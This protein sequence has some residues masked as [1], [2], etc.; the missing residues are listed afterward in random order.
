MILKN[1]KHLVRQYPLS[2][3]LSFVGLTCAFTAFLVIFHQVE[4]EMS[5]DTC[6]PTSERI[7]RADKKE[8]DNMFRSVLPRGFCDDI[9]ASSPHVVAG[10]TFCPFYGETQFSAIGEGTPV[11]VTLQMNIASGGFI[12]VFGIEMLEGDM[13]A[14]E[15]PNCVILP[16]SIA[17]VLFGGK[18]AVGQMLKT[19]AA[20]FLDETDGMVTVTGVYRDFPSNTQLEN[21]VYLSAGH[22]EE[23]S[24]GG[25]NFICYM[26]L[27]DNGNRESVEQQFNGTFDFSKYEGWLTPIE[28]IKY[29]DIYFRNEGNVFKSGSYTQFLLLIAIAVLILLTGMIN[30][31][32]FYI[33][34][35]PMRMKSV[36]TRMVFGVSKWSLQSEVIGE[37]MVWSA[38]AFGLALLLFNPVCQALSEH[39]LTPD[40]FD[41]LSSPMLLVWALAATLVTGAV[42]GILPGVYSTSMEPA[43]ALKGNFG[44]SRSGRMMRNILVYVQ[45]IVS[46][47]LFIYVL[48]IERQGEYIENYPCGFEKENL[49]AVKLGRDMSRRDRVAIK[50]RLCKINGVDNVAFAAALLGG[51]EVYNTNSYDF[52]EGSC[53]MSMIMCSYDFPKVMGMT[54]VDGA[55]FTPTGH[56]DCLITENIKSVGGTLKKMDESRTLIGFVNNVNITSLR[57]AE[58]YVCFVCMGEN[59]E[60]ELPYAY[61]R[62]NSNADKL[63]M[64]DEIR[65]VLRDIDP[66]QSFDLIFYTNIKGLLYSGEERLRKEIWIF[67]MLAILLSLVGIWGQTLMDVKYRGKEI[68]VKRV[69]GASGMQIIG[70]GLRHYGVMVGICFVIACPFAYIASEQYLSQFSR[71]AGMSV[72]PFIVS[73]VAVAALTLSVVAYHYILCLRTNPANV[74]KHE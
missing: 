30:F 54:V 71:H 28:L 67:S 47:V 74:L 16:K 4:Y 2:L 42:A 72:M 18:S 68:S 36:N 34:L 25:A 12:E 43:L 38:L 49:V 24:Y 29:C 59:S 26:L 70:E 51:S 64:A 65:K 22:F 32:N 40:T 14:L 63:A 46:F 35:T 37:S 8:C 66:V 73:L 58:S 10:C 60:S 41:L 13:H 57:K 27:D 48:S 33:A 44:L 45:L 56:N 31:T 9:I 52:G 20:R 11:G 15:N 55:E 5:F 21:C 19:D 6:H 7:Y 69:M 39:G 62:L 23:G 61:I 17:D 53:M 50:E 1:I 3:I